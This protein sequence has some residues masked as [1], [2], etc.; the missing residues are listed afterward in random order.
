MLLGEYP[1]LIKPLTG[2]PAYAL[3]Q[4]DGMTESFQDFLQRRAAASDAYIRGDATALAGM[5]AGQ[6]PATFMP[7]TGAVVEGAGPVAEAQ[8][9]GAAV[10][11]ADST[12]HFEILNSGF[13][14]ALGFW[15]GRQHATVRMGEELVPMVLRTTEVFRR[16]DG[17]WK[18]VH[19]HADRTP[20][21]GE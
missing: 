17:E 15:S 16:E 18:L 4:N 11:G 8:V 14:D 2:R 19:R 12:G 5:L 6:D 10:F 9:E 13:D 20:P 7:P 21:P 3:S 1:T